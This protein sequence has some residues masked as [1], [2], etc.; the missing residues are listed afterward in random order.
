MVWFAKFKME[1]GLAKVI[2]DLYMW[3]VS[4]VILNN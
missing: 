4:T 3:S 2:Q 1:K